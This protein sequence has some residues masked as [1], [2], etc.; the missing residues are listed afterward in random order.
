M[1]QP[2]FRSVLLPWLQIKNT[3]ISF[4]KMIK[5][6]TQGVLK[7]FLLLAFRTAANLASLPLWLLYRRHTIPAV[8]SSLRS[9]VGNCC[10]SVEYF[11]VGSV[12]LGWK[13][14]TLRYQT[15]ICAS[16][17][18]CWV[19]RLPAKELPMGKLFNRELQIKQSLIFHAFFFF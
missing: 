1:Q 10:K 8:L 3:T 15:C 13:A 18:L 11:D 16:I 6:L 9:F 5:L 4:L 2:S 17:A 12:D 7:V 19:L 14:V